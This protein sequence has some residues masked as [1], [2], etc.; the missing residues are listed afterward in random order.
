MNGSDYDKIASEYYL[1]RHIT[2]RN[3]DSA[4]LTSR[5]LVRSLLP[6]AGLVLELGAG[7]GRLEEFFDVPLSRTIQIDLSMKMLRID[8]KRGDRRN[9]NRI[10]CDAL[11]LP[12]C[13]ESF[14]AVVALL[15]DPYNRPRLY[16]EV[17]RVLRRGGIFIGTLPSI[18]WGTTLRRIRKYRVDRVRFIAKSGKK[19]MIDSILVG[20]KE[21]M[22]QVEAAGLSLN[23][24]QQLYLPAKVQKIS[25]DVTT[26]AEKLGLTPETLPLLTLV[27][28]RRK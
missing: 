13:S 24:A 12:F 16:K 27:I 21:L 18:D 4:T 2:S 1:Q 7:K 25:P 15:Y 22:R 17:Q 10:R 14:A 23:E 5:R 9:A 20:R 11:G 28:A 6:H 19:V 26:P 8:R 3:F